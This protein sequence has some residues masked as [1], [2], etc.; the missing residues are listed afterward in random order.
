MGLLMKLTRQSSWESSYTSGL[1]VYGKNQYN[2][3]K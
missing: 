1:M 2:M 3:V